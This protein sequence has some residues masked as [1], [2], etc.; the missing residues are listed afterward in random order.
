MLRTLVHIHG[1][2]L[3]GLIPTSGIA[4]SKINARVVLLNFA[5]SPSIGFVSFRPSLLIII[6]LSD[7]GGFEFAFL[8]F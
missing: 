3:S 1:D 5:R 8:L 6:K 4:G 7:S 2:V